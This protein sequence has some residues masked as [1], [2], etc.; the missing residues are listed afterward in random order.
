MD[1]IGPRDKIGKID[2]IT[3]IG[4]IVIVWL[5]GFVRED[6]LSRG[7]IPERFFNH[8]PVLSRSKGGRA[9]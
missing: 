6:G 8:R 9:T 5:R 4:R 1:I 3:P 7:G 2:S